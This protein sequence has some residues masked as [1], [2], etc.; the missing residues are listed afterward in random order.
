MEALMLALLRA[1]K[2]VPSLRIHAGDDVILRLPV[3]VDS[4]AVQSDDVNCH[5]APRSEKMIHDQ[6]LKRGG[7]PKQEDVGSCKGL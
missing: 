6:M 3:G 7:L 2:A 5:D 1:D 4:E